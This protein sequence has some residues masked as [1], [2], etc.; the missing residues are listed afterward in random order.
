MMHYLLIVVS[1]LLLGCAT[2]HSHKHFSAIEK[3]H[4]TT[5]TCPGKECLC[6]LGP[7]DVWYFNGTIGDLDDG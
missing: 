7:G 5:D 6:I 4:C 1:T 2:T 3:T